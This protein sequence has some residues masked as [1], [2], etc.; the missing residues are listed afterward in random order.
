MAMDARVDLT[1]NRLFGGGAHITI[2][3]F[4]TWS[5]VAESIAL[6]RVF[7]SMFIDTIE[8]Y[9]DNDLRS[10]KWVRVNLSG[11]K[12]FTIKNNNI[13]LSDK[14]EIPLE[15]KTSIYSNMK[16]E[17]CDRLAITT[18]SYCSRCR[19]SLRNSK[20]DVSKRL[21][22]KEELVSITF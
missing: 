11:Y 19:E 16:C 9:D 10:N 18:N 14:I 3:S 21:F 5:Y 4:N 1:E 7:E 2:N 20:Y 8:L 13:C 17:E 15:M 6:H 22:K 12:E